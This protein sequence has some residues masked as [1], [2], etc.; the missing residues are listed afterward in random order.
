MTLLLWIIQSF[1]G[2]FGM[3]MV[4]KMV[5]KRKI[6]N[7]WQT[8]LNRWVHILIL[9]PVV[10]LGFLSYDLPSKEITSFNVF[11]F[12]LAATAISVT[13]PLRRIAYANEKVSILQPFSMLFQVFTI[14]I[15]FI[16][17]ASER[18]NLITFL[19]ALLASLIVI[20]T[21]IDIKKIEINTYSL[22]VL[23]S[24]VI[25]SIQVFIMLYFIKFLSPVT[26][27]ITESFVI[28]GL[29]LLLLIGKKQLWELSVLTKDYAKMLVQTN[30]IAII[31][32]IIALSMYKNLWAVATSLISLLYLVFVYM[33]WYILLKEIPKKKDVI[34]TI[35]VSLCIIIGILFK[36]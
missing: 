11:L 33:F 29:S 8:I 1:F 17:I 22:M 3:V 15:S 21:S 30:T 34:V 35:L 12:I 16:F 26:F 24:S 28:I 13:Y 31:S 14:I 36:K 25:K 23:A 4:K 20:W 5:E 18:V 9:F 10:L 27:Y 19:M 32:I 2:A 7:N 6:G